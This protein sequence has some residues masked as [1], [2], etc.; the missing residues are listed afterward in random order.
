MRRSTF[1]L[2]GSGLSVLS[3]LILVI[4]FFPGCSHK[5][6]QPASSSESEAPAVPALNI[7]NLDTKVKPCMNFYEFADGGWMAS[8]PIPAA[9]PSWSQ[10][11]ELAKRNKET[12]RRLLEKDAADKH[13][14]HGSN[15]QKLGDFYASCM[16]TQKIEAEGA[17][18]LNPEF[19]RIEQIHDVKS[20]QAEIARLQ[21]MGINALFGFGSEQDFKNSSMMIGDA[22]QGGLG[23]PNCTYY[24]KQDAKSKQIREQYVAHVAKMLELL[25]DPAAKAKAES[26]T[27]MKLETLL[28]KSSMTPV[29][30]RNPKA[31]YHKMDAAHLKR[32]M[33]DFSWDSY[34]EEIGHPL[35]N[36]INIGQPD[37]FK[38]VN[39][40]LKTE[41]LA[42]W[43]TYLKW[44]LVDAAAPYLSQPFVQENFNFNGKVL[45][46]TKEILPRW[47]R[48]VNAADGGLGMALGEQYV[49]EAFPPAAK[50]RALAMVNN[51]ISALRSDISTLSWMGP[52]TK[53]QAIA[54]LQLLVKKIGYPEKWRDYS[55]L[56]IT[57][58]PYVDNVFQ[59]DLFEF[60][61]EVNKINKPVDRTEWQMTPPTV[62]AYYDP[63]MNEIV[64][65]AGILQP[66]FFN[67]KADDA[68]NYGAM[69][70]VIG[71][72]MT[73]GFDDEGRQFDAHGNLVNWWT[74]EDLKRFQAR[75]QC[76]EKQFDGYQVEDGLHEN[77]KLV[78]G[79]SIADLGGLAIAYAAFQQTPEAKSHQKIDGFTPDQ[80]F[81]LSYGQIWA[82]NIRPQFARMLVSVDP[83]PIP[84]FRVNGP[85]S[86]MPA[87]AQAWDCK[88]GE[89]M[90]RPPQ[91]QCKIW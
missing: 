24:T 37:F 88:S 14:A 30:L 20:L 84:R 8:N 75:A 15:E 17:K 51:L 12:L 44:Q 54:K 16:N 3:V 59:A 1:R 79:E 11:Q 4:L 63:T 47:H 64:F 91:D 43:K 56:T 42:D 61:R 82:Q 86:N 27:V 35:P 85:L 21:S 18:P 29:E 89:P 65:P 40:A 55:A 26:E 52:E 23:L 13:A 28:A 38:T 31:V 81:F 49:Q 74:P 69:G 22:E 78:L 73:H 6:Q 50:A 83:H 87:F 39:K 62:N 33:P 45:T 25:G 68:V 67:P 77:G 9:Y 60:H 90:V 53:K 72:E 80:R 58:G 10:F 2:A 32:L 76:V 34:F 70:V 36:S 19:K 48:C 5:A 66:P 57:R 41:P 71:H 46:G 7:K